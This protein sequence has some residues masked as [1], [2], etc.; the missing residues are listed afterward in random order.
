[1]FRKTI[2]LVGAGYW[3][4]NLV[5][6]FSELGVLKTIC[7]LDKK[8]LGERKKEH[9]NLKTT[10]DFSEILKDKEIKGVVIATPAATHYQLAKKALEGGKD[11]LVE[12][13]L[14]LNV[15]EGNE[16][17]KLAQKKKL[18]LMV[19]HQY[20]YNPAILKIKELIKKG[21]LGEIEYIFSRRVKFGIFRKVENVFWSFAPHDIS[22]IIDILGMPK[23][24][25]AVGKSYLQKNI[26][27][28]VLSSFKFNNNKAGHIFTSWL[29]PVKE[30]KI[31]IIGSK[32]MLV[33][34]D[35]DKI[36]TLHPYQI[37]RNKNLAP[38]AK[39]IGEKVIKFSSKEP[40][41]EEAK[42]FLDCIKKRKKPETDGA[43]AI[44][45][46]KVLNACQKS[47]NQNGKKI[48]VS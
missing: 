24:V 31:T 8:V 27:D 46:L 6:V 37:E 3:G 45:V 32:K 34:N 23:E 28:F 5:R 15:K 4:K 29:S 10:T 14:V 9:P 35:A 20:F 30:Q 11:V 38:K 42:H 33:L 36:L 25:I 7:D 21:E 44:R 12:K 17:V 48:L 26:Q 1:M 19:G 41:K 43:E 13:P 18:I 47:I 39:N 16:L 2:G 40:L 22:T